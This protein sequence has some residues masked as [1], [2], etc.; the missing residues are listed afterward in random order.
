MGRFLKACWLGVGAL[1]FLAA[2][3]G[4]GE[5]HACAFTD[6]PGDVP[7]SGSSGVVPADYPAPVNGGH[8]SLVVDGTPE[9]DKG[10]LGAWLVTDP[11][12]SNQY[13]QIDGKTTIVSVPA[14]DIG[15]YSMP[16]PNVLLTLGGGTDLYFD[17][18]LTVSIDGNAQG[19]VWGRLDGVLEGTKT[20]PFTVTGK[21]SASISAQ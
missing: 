10:G 14:L 3:C 2:A 8:F 5:D 1:G 21:F 7:L 18:S 15:A 17:D 11:V 13:Y 4:G 9:E 12:P 20:S 16:T 19:Y 6:C